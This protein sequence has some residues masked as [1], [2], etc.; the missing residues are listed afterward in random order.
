MSVNGTVCAIYE[1]TPFDKMWYSQKFNTAV[2]RY[3][4]GLC[5]FYDRIC[6]KYSPLSSGSHPDQAMFSIKLCKLL[7]GDKM[8][9][10]DGG[11][12]VRHVLKEE[13]DVVLFKRLGIVM[14]H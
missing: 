13:K 3:E 9:V 2:L 12:S 10:A 14:K 11:F 5:I 8:L 1:P 7:C 6:W 4:V